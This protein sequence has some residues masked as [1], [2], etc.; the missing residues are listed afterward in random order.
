MGMA[1]GREGKGRFVEVFFKRHKGTRRLTKG[2][3][4]T[5]L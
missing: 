1:L 3:L 4:Y 5:Y 2:I